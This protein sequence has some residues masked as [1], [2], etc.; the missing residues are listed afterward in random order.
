MEGREVARGGKRGIME[1]ERRMWRV[2]EEVKGGGKK[3]KPKG[4][5]SYNSIMQQ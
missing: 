5:R 1:V 4:W 3:E 2:R